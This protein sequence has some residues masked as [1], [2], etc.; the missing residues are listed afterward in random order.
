LFIPTNNGLPREKGDAKLIDA[1][2]K[3]DIARATEN[4]I[5]VIRADVAGHDGDLVAYGSSAIVGPDGTI[6][7]SAR[8]LS[9]DLIVADI[10]TM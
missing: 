9:A 10:K 2:R 5:F 4:R 3:A 7:R 8:Q 6:L 1:A